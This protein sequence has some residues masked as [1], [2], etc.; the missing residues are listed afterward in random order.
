MS[1]RRSAAEPIS[2]LAA[3]TQI[4]STETANFAMK[5]MVFLFMRTV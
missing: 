4:K 3:I 5:N 1:L 2:K